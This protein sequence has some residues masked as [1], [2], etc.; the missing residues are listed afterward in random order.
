[1]EGDPYDEG[2]FMEYDHD[3]RPDELMRWELASRT[4]ECDYSKLP[5]LDPVL[6]PDARLWKA[7][8]NYSGGYVRTPVEMLY[9]MFGQYVTH[10]IVGE[11]M[12]CLAIQYIHE[13]QRDTGVSGRDVA[14]VASIFVRLLEACAQDFDFET[15]SDKHCRIVLRTFRPFEPDAP[16]ALRQAFFQF[17]EMGTRILNGHIRVTRNRD[18][19]NG[20]AGPEIWD[21]K[22]TGSWLW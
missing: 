10:F 21:F 8:R 1:M 7:R 14:S 4:P 3:L 2:Y 15:V 19:L 17:Q 5:R 16:E 12:R 13:L 6:W 20:T 18:A 11:T 9:R 22:D